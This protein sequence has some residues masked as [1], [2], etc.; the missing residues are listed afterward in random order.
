MPTGVPIRDLREQLLDAAERVLLRDGPDALTSRALTTEAGVAKGILH[1]HFPDF[2]TF[3]AALVL[4]GIERVEARSAELRAAAG[5]AAVA[6][7]LAQAL[8]DVLQPRAMR[9]ISLAC[10]RQT[11]RERLRLTTPAGIPVLVESTK[12]VAAYLTAE[13][14]LGRIA[15]SADVDMLAMLLVGGAHLLAAGCDGSAPNPDDLHILVGTVIDKVA[16]QSSSRPMSAIDAR[17]K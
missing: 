14:G 16:P 17:P 10:S 2:D 3:L 11:L 12:M 13:R 7:N 1:R 15:L 6:D 5:S 9:I 4:A 8:A